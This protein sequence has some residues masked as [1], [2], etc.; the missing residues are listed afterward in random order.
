VR[1]ATQTSTTDEAY[2]AGGE[3]LWRYTGDS[4]TRSFVPFGGDILAEYY[5][6][7]TLFDHYD[8]L[9]SITMSTSYNGSGSQERLFYPFGELWTGAGSSGMHQT[10]AKLPD[11]DAETDQYNTLNRHY[12]PSGRWMSPDPG[13]LKVVRLDDPQT[14]NMYAYVRNN[15]TTLTDPTGLCDP[16][17]TNSA[18]EVIQG[19]PV[20]PNNADKSVELNS[21]PKHDNQSGDKDRQEPTSA[22]TTRTPSKGP[23]D[24]TVHYPGPKPGKGTDRTY[25]PDGRAV[26]DVD[27]GHDHKGV[28]DPHAHDWD[29]SGEKPQRGDDRSLTP[30][31]K[32]QIKDTVKKVAPVVGIG[33]AIGA[34]IQVIIQT[35]P[36]WAPVLAF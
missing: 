16:I 23:P 20:D 21:K 27:T 15:P 12:T 8:E 3:L 14:W 36:E 5:S 4:N 26:K 2:G 9:G 22:G 19:V 28:G 33:A 18:C 31:E 35:A 34:V 17:A 29:W 13:G 6:G 24:T 7:G 10:F 32:D 30:E 11:Y 1:D 25:G